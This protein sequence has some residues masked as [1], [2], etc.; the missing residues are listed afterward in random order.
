MSRGVLAAFTLTLFATACGGGGDDD[1]A[2]TTE[3]CTYLP[4]PATAGSGGTVAPGALTA[5]VAERRIDVPVGAALAAY[6]ARAGFLGEAGTVDTRKVAISSTFNPSIGIESA[7]LV[8][9]LALTAGGETI[10]LLKLDLG[11][12]Y[13]GMVFD[14][15]DR[16]G[17][18]YTGKV[19][20]SAS[21]SH[22]AWGHFSAHSAYQLGSGVFRDL[23]YTRYLDSMEAAARAA[24]D[25]R[26]PAKLGVFVDFDF[27]P[28][29]QIS[30]D[31]RGENN[32]LMGGPRKDDRLFMFRID[33]VEGQPMVAMPVYGI[34]G[35]LNGEDNSLASTDVVGATERMLAEAIPGA[36]VMH[37]QGAGADVSPTGHGGLD[38]ANPPGDP[39]DPCFPWLSA[40]GNARMATPVLLAAWEAAGASMQTDVQ[41]ESMT[42]SIELGPY[43]ETFTVRGGA[44]EY[45]P[46][47]GLTEPDRQIFGNGGEVLSPIDEFNAPVGAGLCE[48]AETLYYVA[49]MPGTEELAPY[50]SCAKVDLMTEVFEILLDTQFESDERH[51]IC[52]STR[53]TL[54]AFRIGDY[55]F[56]TLPGEPTVM[57]A[58]FIREQSPVDPEHTVVLG[59][60][61]GEV[62]YILR[63]EDWL[64]GGYESSINL[65]G[66]LE[67]EYLAEQLIA[68]MSLAATPEREDATTGGTDRCA[69]PQV[70]DDLPIDDPAPMAGTV[71]A[72]V[73]EIAWLRSGVPASTQPPATIPRVSG[74]A[75]LVF[76]G[77]D[78]LVNTPEV[79][80]EYETGTDTWAAV[81]RRSGRLVQEGEILLA[82]T[83]DPLRRDG[84]NPQT[85]Y[86]TVEWQ[87]VPWIGCR[88]GSVDCDGMDA[89]AGVPLGRYRFHV[90]GDGWELD[91]D[92]FEVTAA[93][94]QLAAARNGNAIE[95]TVNLEAPRGW[96]LLDLQASSNRPVPVRAGSFDVTLAG[97]NLDFQDQPISSAGVISVDAGAQAGNVTSVTVTDAW[98]NTA[99]TN[100]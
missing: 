97:A 52:Q 82:T 14:L 89:F 99:T 19:I 61:Q 47:D 86:W 62:G 68:L 21:H 83:P 70:V 92:P 53:T 11:Y 85:H 64:L 77:D 98:G 49:V 40:E 1:T 18:E 76:I 87:A 96:R 24:L 41:L 16:L 17:P 58:D 60:T 81:Q 28:E 9:A 6:T 67:G 54:T 45:A 69:V 57:I 39:A 30:R 88:D 4:M 79:T 35:T 78:P 84:D 37:L 36:I 26:V 74:L 71:P 32:D 13:E 3:H 75:T 55:V 44:L 56:G 48:T 51:P 12:P 43:P 8:K 66:P 27:D 5:G 25:A 80:L 59:Y 72:T 15:E 50:A 95:I 29:D 93:N 38:C 10:I 94:L 100:L 65:W 34:H 90:A 33:T 22:S 2:V 63:P 46:F 20:V 7:P 23:A 91:S 31:R 73:P 42:R